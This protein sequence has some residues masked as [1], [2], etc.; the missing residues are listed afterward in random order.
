MPSSINNAIILPQTTQ[1]AEICTGCVKVLF[2]WVYGLILF[3]LPSQLFAF[4][5]VMAWGKWMQGM[6]FPISNLLVLMTFSPGL[7]DHLESTNP[8]VR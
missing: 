8:L 7:K 6:N 2:L 1:A 3:M 4:M 5:S